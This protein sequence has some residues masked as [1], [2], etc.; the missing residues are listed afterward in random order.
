[1]HDAV[2]NLAQQSATQYAIPSG[3]ADPFDLQQLRLVRAVNDKGTSRGNASAMVQQAVFCGIE[4]TMADDGMRFGDLITLARLYSHPNATTEQPETPIICWTKHS[5]MNPSAAVNTVPL[6]VRAHSVFEATHSFG[7]LDIVL[8]F[9]VYCENHIDYWGGSCMLDLAETP[10]RDPQRLQRGTHSHFGVN[11]H[12]FIHEGKD[13]IEKYQTRKAKA[14]KDVGFDGPTRFVLHNPTDRGYL[15][16][17][18]SLPQSE[19]YDHLLVGI[20]RVRA[21]AQEEEFFFEDQTSGHRDI[22]SDD[23]FWWNLTGEHA[24]NEDIIFEATPRALEM[25]RTAG[26]RNKVIVLEK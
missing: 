25:L 17:T 7:P 9:I 3:C 26:V 4:D 11:I 5:T 8:G 23:H 22:A 14:L 15:D 2:K 19:D 1:M 10:V 16:G 12:D 21:C 18:H 24:C 20:S 6:I 13:G